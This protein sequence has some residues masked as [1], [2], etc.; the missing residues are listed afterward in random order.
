MTVYIHVYTFKPE[1]EYDPFSQKKPQAA[2]ER[3]AHH[4]LALPAGQFEQV[5]VR[6]R[7]CV[8]VCACVCVFWFV[9]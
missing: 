6:V 4:G 2:I 3:A 7:A 9:C 5:P 1:A 8:C